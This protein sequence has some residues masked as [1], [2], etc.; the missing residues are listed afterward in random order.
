MFEVFGVLVLSVEK[1]GENL[2]NLNTS[3]CQL[4]GETR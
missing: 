1:K 3:Y 2:I 4:R